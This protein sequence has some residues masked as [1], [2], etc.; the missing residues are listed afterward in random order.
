MTVQQITSLYENA[1][2]REEQVNLMDQKL[3]EEKHKLLEQATKIP[4]SYAKEDPEFTSKP[5][6][7]L[8]EDE[9]TLRVNK[10]LTQERQHHREQ[11]RAMEKDL[12]SVTD[13]KIKVRLDNEHLVKRIGSCEQDLR[14]A[15]DHLKRLT[16]EKT[17]MA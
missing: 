3:R 2:E 1:V 15:T 16:Q 9:I 5:D 12:K 11:L 7:E 14:E 4:L 17:K 10:V 6:Q 8:I 13:E